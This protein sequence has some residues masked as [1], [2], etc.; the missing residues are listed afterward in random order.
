MQRG[1]EGTARRHSERT[2]REEWRV[3][4]RDQF[5]VVWLALVPTVLMHVD[6]E[7]IEPSRI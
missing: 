6:H 3:D 7:S 1:A 2:Q 5:A 4:E